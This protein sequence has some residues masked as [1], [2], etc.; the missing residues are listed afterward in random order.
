MF[1][2]GVVSEIRIY[3]LMIESSDSP[4]GGMPRPA[5]PADAQRIL[6][7]IQR[8]SVQFGT[9]IHIENGIGIIRVP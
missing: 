9:N 7:R 8:D 5:S 4:T 2:G 6:E 1:R 3:P